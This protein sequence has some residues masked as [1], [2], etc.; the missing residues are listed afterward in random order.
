[1]H[2]EYQLI[3]PPTTLDLHWRPLDA[4]DRAGIGALI[5]EC[6]AR[7]GGLGFMATEPSFLKRF[8]SENPHPG[9]GGFDKNA[10]LM[11]SA[12]ARRDRGSDEDSVTLVGNVHPN[13]RRRGLG[14]Y[15][16]TWSMAQAQ[17]LFVASADNLPRAVYIR[18]ESLTDDA[19]KLYMRFGFRRVFAE[20]VMRR[21]MQL[22]LPDAPFPPDIKLASWRAEL[23]NQFFEA[24]QASF[25]DRPGFPNP[26]ADDWISGTAND[27]DFRADLS[28]LALQVGQP[29]GFIACAKGWVSQMGVRPEWR[30]KGLGTALLVRALAQM[31]DEGDK[32]A[33]LDVNANNSTATRVYTRLGFTVVG[34]RG[35]YEWVSP[36]VAAPSE[37]PTA[38]GTAA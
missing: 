5:A 31:R 2:A 20:N 14:D 17:T 16:L 19:E 13:Y 30:G 29:V 8:V 11:A 25:R 22:P 12:A 23:A 9:I 26:S 21:E 34:R 10:R 4:N 33:M 6:I 7:D 15:L 27:D 24:Y 36:F 18:T 3:T 37:T 28:W 38:S 1:M 32:F 35:K